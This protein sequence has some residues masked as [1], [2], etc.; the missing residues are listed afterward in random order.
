MP[1]VLGIDSSL[2]A[3]GLCRIDVWDRVSGVRDW[4]MTCATVGAP[5]P[6]PNKTKRR[7]AYR[8]NKLIEQIEGA[9][10]DPDCPTTAEY[11]DLIAIEELAYAAK[12]ESAWVLPWIF[13]RVIELAEKYDIPLIAVGTKARAKYVTNN[14][15]AGKDEVMLAAV[16]LWPEAGITNNN[17]SDAAIVGAVG[18][19]YLG[20]PICAETQYRGDVLAKVSA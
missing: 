2:T 16:K 1:R 5:K 17:E 3:T 4:T 13:G 18:C 9:I 11:P 14:G 7:M 8:V 20:L 10:T 12:G 15:N 19:H 6:T